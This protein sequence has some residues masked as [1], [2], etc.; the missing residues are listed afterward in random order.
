MQVTVEFPDEIDLDSHEAREIFVVALYG[1]GKLSEK[2]ACDM[3]NASRREFQSLLEEY[4]VPY[5]TA[6]AASARAEVRAAER[7]RS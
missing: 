5:M 4:G 3:L 6:D 2:E 7:R 1:R